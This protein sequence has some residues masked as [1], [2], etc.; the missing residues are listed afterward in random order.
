MF[1]PGG[2]ADPVVGMHAAVALQAAL[3]EREASGKGQLVEIA[4]I[5]VIAS[6]TAE[7]VIRYSLAGELMTRDGN[8]AADAAPQG[9]YRCAGDDEWLALTVRDDDDWV[10][11][12]RVLGDPEWAREPRLRSLAGRRDQH[13]TIDA[14]L[15][16]WTSS[17]DA[18]SMAERLLAA[19]IPAAAL[20]KTDA[21]YGEPQLA[22][23]AYFQTLEHPVTGPLRYPGWPTQFSFLSPTPLPYA[24]SAPTLGQ[25]N[26]EILGGVLGLT[27]EVLDRLREARV[28]GETLG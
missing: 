25:H 28:I 23:R 10:A 6:L 5:E 19:D 7:Q 9:I 12:R 1:A 3:A 18:R 13:D 4:Q 11:L 24:A 8:Q 22:A 17:R 21:I 15:G 27:R 16:A 2:F 14:R 26:D 20:L